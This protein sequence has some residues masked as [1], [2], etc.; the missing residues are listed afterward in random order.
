M[1]DRR[2]SQERGIRGSVPHCGAKEYSGCKRRRVG[3][4]S[5]KAQKRDG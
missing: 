4:G 2:V 3:G 5:G 1:K